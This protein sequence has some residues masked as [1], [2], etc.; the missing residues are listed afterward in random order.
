[1]AIHLNREAVEHAQYLIKGRQ[2]ERESD[3]SE[4][5]PSAEVENNFIDEN[6]WERSRGGT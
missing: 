2:Y 1:M 6:G 3:W 5:Q 4:A